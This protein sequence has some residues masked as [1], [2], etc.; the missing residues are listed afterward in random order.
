MITYML[1]QIRVYLINLLDAFLARGVAYILERD[2]VIAIAESAEQ[3]I[4]DI[5]NAKTGARDIKPEYRIITIRG[6]EF[7]ITPVSKGE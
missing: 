4:V 6:K 2:E 5:A 3:L 7:A 1:E